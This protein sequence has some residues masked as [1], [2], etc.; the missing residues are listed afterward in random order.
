MW[1]W[2][3]LDVGD[4]ITYQSCKRRVSFRDEQI[5]LLTRDLE[6]ERFAKERLIAEARSR[7]EQYENRLAQMQGEYE[8]ARREADEAHEE[9]ESLRRKQFT[10]GAL[11]VLPYLDF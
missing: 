8:H 1:R 3:A 11:S 2:Y 9:A 5:L 10:L 7:I 4:H 6:D